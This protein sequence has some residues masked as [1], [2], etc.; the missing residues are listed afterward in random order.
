MNQVESEQREQLSYS[1]SEVSEVFDR[2]GEVYKL[3]SNNEYKGLNNLGG[4]EKRDSQEDIDNQ[5]L[6]QALAKYMTRSHRQLNF[7]TEDCSNNHSILH[8]SNE[9][10]RNTI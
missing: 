9:F 5:E 3:K 1:H 7:Q 2:I 8:D 6:N 10:L 4:D